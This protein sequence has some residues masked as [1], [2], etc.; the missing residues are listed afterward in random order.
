MTLNVFWVVVGGVNESLLEEVVERRERMRMS[1]WDDDKKEY[2]CVNEQVWL[3]QQR[4][5]GV[6][7]EER[8]RMKTR[9]SIHRVE[10]RM[11]HRLSSNCLIE[12][13]TVRMGT[14]TNVFC[15][16]SIMSNTT[17]NA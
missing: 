9:C 4:R 5:R 11:A 10:K 13:V 17:K 7:E 12:P 14:I 6:K 8:R 16:P 1:E 3:T 15:Q 2:C